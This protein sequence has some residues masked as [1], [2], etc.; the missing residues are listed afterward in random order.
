MKN[1][2]KN[3]SF[4]FIVAIVIFVLAILFLAFILINQKIKTGIS[5]TLNTNSSIVT[6]D[7][8][9][10]LDNNVNANSNVA[11]ASTADSNQ[12]KQ[13]YADG[14][15]LFDAQ[16]YKEAIDKFTAA[17]KLDSKEPNYFSKKSQAEKNLGLNSEAISTIESGLKSNPD[18][19]LLKTRLDILQKQWL[20]N[21]PE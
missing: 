10:Q 11:V 19:D 21:Q 18:S 14:L 20:G 16:K 8:T 9:N 5:E 17:I 1:R 4:L 13:F 15:A 3:N 6:N 12:A 7:N 2:D